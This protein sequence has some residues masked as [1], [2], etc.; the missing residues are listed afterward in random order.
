MQLSLSLP[1]FYD[2]NEAL[3][4]LLDLNLTKDLYQHL[5]NQKKRLKYT[6]STS[7][8]LAA[9]KFCYPPD[10]TLN[11]TE[12]KAEVQLQ[13]LLD[14]TAQRVLLMNQDNITYKSDS[15]I[16][17]MTLICKWGFDGTSGQSIYKMTFEDPDISDANLFFTSLVPLQLVGVNQETKK[18]NLLIRS[19][20]Q[21]SFADL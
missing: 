1:A 7:A 5:R 4:L 8:V 13:T 21:P 16:L 20:L 9:K 3:A 2:S 15:E 18:E 14:H 10:D 17:N 6:L 11:F 19:H 12:S